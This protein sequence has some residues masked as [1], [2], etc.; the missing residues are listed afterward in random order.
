MLEET[1]Y[2]HPDDNK[3]DANEK[4]H[5]GVT[6][7]FEIEVGVNAKRAGKRK[8]HAENKSADPVA[9]GA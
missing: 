4:S 8:H 1:S 2:S 7:Y 5:P 6:G 3:N 9:A